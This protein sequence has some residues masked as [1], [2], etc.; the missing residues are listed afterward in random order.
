MKYHTNPYYKNARFSP[1]PLW[2]W[3]AFTPVKITWALQRYDVELKGIFKKPTGLLKP[4]SL[5]NKRFLVKSQKIHI[6]VCTIICQMQHENAMSPNTKTQCRLWDTEDFTKKYTSIT[7]QKMKFSIKDFFSKCD[8]IRSFLRI[9][10]HLLKKSL[11]E[12]F[13]FCAVHIQ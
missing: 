6:Y 8:Q 3:N 13:T 12:N 1:K 2:V 9:W 4:S 11:M 10:S 7:A 5:P